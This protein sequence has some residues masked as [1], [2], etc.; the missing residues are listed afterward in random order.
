MINVAAG[1]K[2]APQRHGQQAIRIIILRSDL[3]GIMRAGTSPLIHQ[4]KPEIS[5]LN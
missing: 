1:Q 2:Y 5:N 3:Y 4:K